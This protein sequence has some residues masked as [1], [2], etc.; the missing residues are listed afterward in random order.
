[1]PNYS[2]DAFGFSELSAEMSPA[3]ILTFHGHLTGASQNLEYL[4]LEIQP[5]EEELCLG[6]PFLAQEQQRFDAREIVSDESGRT[7]SFV[8]SPLSPV[9]AY[10]WR[11]LAR[12]VYAG[13]PDVLSEIQVVSKDKFSAEGVRP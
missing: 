12:N 13:V 8:Y 5:V 2:R 7:F 3:G 10:R 6:C 1:M 11:L 9:T 4:V